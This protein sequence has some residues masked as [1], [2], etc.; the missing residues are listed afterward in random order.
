MHVKDSQKNKCRI[1]FEWHPYNFVNRTLLYYK[2][3]V[4]LKILYFIRRGAVSHIKFIVE[5]ARYEE[6]MFVHYNR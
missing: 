6:K 4:N 1:L 3:N 2:F 5:T